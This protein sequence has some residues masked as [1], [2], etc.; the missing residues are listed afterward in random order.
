MELDARSDSKGEGMKNFPW[1]RNFLYISN[2]MARRRKAIGWPGTGT[3]WELL[4]LQSLLTGLL[5]IGLEI[6]EKWHIF[7][8]KPSVY[9][10]IKS[11]I[12]IFSLNSN[13]WAS[14]VASASSH[15]QACPGLVNSGL[16]FAPSL[17]TDDRMVG[18][19]LR[20]P[21]DMNDTLVRVL[22]ILYSMSREWLFPASDGNWLGSGLDCLHHMR[23]ASRGGAK[24]SLKSRVPSPGLLSGLRKAGKRGESI[25]TK[26]PPLKGPLL[27]VIGDLYCS[28]RYSA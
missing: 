10:F 20:I 8:D 13:Y 12:S 16:C 26:A 18:T 9:P 4:S 27:R 11:Y 15:L 25:N 22:K 21:G 1:R 14:Y 5:S 19:L 2:W 3:A 17:A 23:R 24:E 7:K 28:S 6:E